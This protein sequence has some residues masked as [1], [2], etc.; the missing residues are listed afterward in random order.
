MIQD[1]PDHSSLTV[2]RDRLSLGVHDQVFTW[3]LALAK[4]V[5]GRLKTGHP[6]A[7]QNQPGDCCEKGW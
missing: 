1:S 5:S 7:P 2:I 3:V 4:D 6:R